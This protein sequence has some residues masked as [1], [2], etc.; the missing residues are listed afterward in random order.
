[1]TGNGTFLGGTAVLPGEPRSRPDELAML[2]A[3]NRLR[4][5]PSGYRVKVEQAYF[6]ML[7][8]STTLKQEISET[9]I[10]RWTM[11][12]EGVVVEH[13]T[14]RRSR[15]QQLCAAYHDLL[16][17][18]A[19]APSVQPLELSHELLAVAHDHA[20]TDARDNY[21]EH[22][23]RDGSLPED[24]IRRALPWVK[25]G[26]ENIAAGPGDAEDILLQLMVDSGVDGR[27]HR[28]NLLNPDWRYVA[29]LKVD[30]ISSPDVTWW[31]QEF[32]R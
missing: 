17:D 11:L 5:D 22:Q 6:D 18:L 30:A 29:C 14:L 23:G 27:G 3:I 9:V 8:D 13:D 20:R 31:V 32:A 19:N 26:N 21:L 28:Q 4:M 2:Q 1:V 25:E 24:R 15:F 12:D 10:T 7:R 16:I